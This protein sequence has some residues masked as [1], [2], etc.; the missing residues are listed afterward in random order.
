MSRDTTNG[1]TGPGDLEE[2]KGDY[3]LFAQLRRAELE[4]AN[5]DLIGDTTARV[6]GRLPKKLSDSS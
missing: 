2:C 1:C 4:I 5:V 3:I 6:S